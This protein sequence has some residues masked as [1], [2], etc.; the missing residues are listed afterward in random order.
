[1]AGHN[2]AV[3]ASHVSDGCSLTMAF[4]RVGTCGAGVVLVKA[5][6]MG[7]AVKHLGAIVGSGRAWCGDHNLGGFRRWSRA[8][9][10]HGSRVCTVE[11]S[12]ASGEAPKAFFVCHI[13]DRLEL[14]KGSGGIRVSKPGVTCMGEH[15]GG[16]EEE[17]GKIDG[18]GI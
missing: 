15:T 14:S 7:P 3:A 13:E 9:C 10:F 2:V 16:F 6:A 18:D 11:A 4:S 17:V 12:L 8:G 1:M 5:K